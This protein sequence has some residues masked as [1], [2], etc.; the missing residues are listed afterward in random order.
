MVYEGDIDRTWK[1][2]LRN[3]TKTLLHRV[4]T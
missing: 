3:D 1:E 2:L 4:L